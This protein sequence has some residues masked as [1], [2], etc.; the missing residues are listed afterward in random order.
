VKL[1]RLPFGQ[2][3]HCR[4]CH[5]LTYRSCQKSHIHDRIL[6][7]IGEGMGM[8]AREVKNSIKSVDPVLYHYDRLL[9]KLGSLDD[10][11]ADRETGGGFF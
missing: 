7:Q 5:G 6:A 4:I 9:D 11:E 8:T 10:P 1:Y 3:Y 2:T